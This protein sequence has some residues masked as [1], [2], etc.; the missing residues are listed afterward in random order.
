MMSYEL[1]GGQPMAHQEQ[2][3]LM[4]VKILVLG[5]LVKKIQCHQKP[6]SLF[7]TASKGLWTVS[8]TCVQQALRAYRTSTELLFLGQLLGQHMSL[9][10]ACRGSSRAGTRWAAR[11]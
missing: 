4:Y 2:Q 5:E 1:L 3:W 8:C 7:Q 9:E 6:Q 10:R 11:T